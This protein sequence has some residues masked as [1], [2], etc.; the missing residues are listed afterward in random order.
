MDESLTSLEEREGVS[1]MVAWPGIPFFSESLRGVILSRGSEQ[2]EI[3]EAARVV[4]PLGR[5]VAL[6]AGE[7]TRSLME[8]LNLTVLMEEEGIIVA[9]K[10]RRETLPLTPLRVS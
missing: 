5:V 9:I 6:G 2:R 10:E 8:G 7:G 4:A 1:R 3:E